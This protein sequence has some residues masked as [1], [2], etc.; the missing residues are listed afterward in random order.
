MPPWERSELLDPPSPPV[1]PTRPSLAKKARG[2]ERK[3]VIDA[4]QRRAARADSVAMIL[5]EDD[6]A[7]SIGASAEDVQWMAEA[8]A[9][10]DPENVSANTIDQLN[11]NWRAW[12]RFITRFNINGG[13]MRPE[14]GDLNALG[15][16]RE[17]V[18]WSCALM[19]IWGEMKPANGKFLP[20]GP[21][22]FGAPKPPSPESALAILRGVRRIHT[23]A[24]I[25][26][27][28]LK[29]AT[30]RMTELMMQYAKDVGPENVAPV[31]KA[32]LTH[33]SSSPTCCT[34]GTARPS[35]RA[36]SR[37]TGAPPTAARR[38]RSSP[39][40]RRFSARRSSR[41]SRPGAPPCGA[42][43]LRGGRPLRNLSA[44]GTQHPGPRRQDLRQ[45]VLAVPTGGR[46]PRDASLP[47]YQKVETFFL[48]P[49]TEVTL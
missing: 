7:Y 25:E 30:R 22:H 31:R 9:V 23:D 1:V 38:A 8:A 4:R 39:T 14:L 21:P 19:W 2:S 43:V 44:G 48:D 6:S 15:R 41:H 24:G 32:P 18:I 3:A 45:R 29:L 34:S 13:S 40:Q 27:P 28:S 20:P 46:T 5:Q 36:A 33:T 47:A 12:C 35:S 11:S 16:K 49:T 10:G 42:R 17:Q 26:T 37:G